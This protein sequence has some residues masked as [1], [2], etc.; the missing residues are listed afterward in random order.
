MIE[1]ENVAEQLSRTSAG[2]VPGAWFKTVENA[3]AIVGAL[4]YLVQNT[5]E[6][7]EVVTEHGTSDYGSLGMTVLSEQFE[8]EYP[9]AEWLDHEIGK[10]RKVYRRKVIVIEDWTEVPE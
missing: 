5:P 4:Q 10:G 6:L 3:R 8:R 7:A 2:L 9:L 1:R